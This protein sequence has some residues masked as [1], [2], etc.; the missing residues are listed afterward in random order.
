MTFIIRNNDGTIVISLL[1]EGLCYS[2]A[3]ENECK[4]IRKLAS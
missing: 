4:K 2:K 1:R 3:H